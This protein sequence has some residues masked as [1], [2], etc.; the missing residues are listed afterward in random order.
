MKKGIK[1]II[2]FSTVTFLVILLRVFAFTSCFIPSSSGMGNTLLDG[3]RICVNKWSYGLRLPLM[4]A[5]SYHRWRE[6]L[7]KEENI[8][9]FNNPASKASKIIDE[10]EVF[11]GRCIGVPGDTLLTDSLFS[12]VIRKTENNPDKKQLYVYPTTKEGQM[13]SLLTFLSISPN[14]LM[15]NSKQGHI[16]SFSSYE[17]YLLKQSIHG[18]CWIKPQLQKQITTMKAFVVPG[19]GLSIR[20]NPWNIVLLRNTLVLHEGKNAEIK[21]G[22]LYIDNHPSTYCHFTKNYY[23]MTSGNSVNISD[24]RLFGFVPQDHII[25][26]PI[27]IWFSKKSE[28]DLFNG[29]R[30]KRFFNSVN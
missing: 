2:A 22:I 4:S 27:F 21:N 15:G 3:E 16:R 29:Y 1:W 5:F 13:D 8:V 20:V 23:W 30:W 26:K 9:V 24:S 10:R 14:R 28:T 25:G 7:V 11:I 6:R 18:E 19:K 17:Y 12:N